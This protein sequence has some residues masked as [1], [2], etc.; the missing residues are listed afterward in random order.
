M[1]FTVQIGFY[2][3]PILGTRKYSSLIREINLKKL[4]QYV[5]KGVL[6]V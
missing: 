2:S 6:G 3:L 5:K 4:L 1:M